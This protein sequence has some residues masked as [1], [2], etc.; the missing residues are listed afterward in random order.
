MAEPAATGQGSLVHSSLGVLGVTGFLMKDLSANPHDYTQDKAMHKRR[1]QISE[2]LD[3]TDP[4][5][6]ARLYVVPQGGHGLSGRSFKMNGDGELVMIR[7]IPAPYPSDKM[8]MIIS[9]VEE[10]NA[11]AETLVINT[12]GRIGVNPAGKGYILCSYPNY[13]KYIGG[14]Q[15]Q[16]DSFISARQ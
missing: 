7:N 3:A 5:E 2:W 8:D 6:F 16:V 14:P 1:R 11:P 9:W 13:P 10:G 15:D 4:D 12:D